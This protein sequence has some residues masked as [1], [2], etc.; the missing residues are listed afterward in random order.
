M[1]GKL[2]SKS[3]G[4]FDDASNA[5]II[6]E[7]GTQHKLFDGTSVSGRSATFTIRPGTVAL[8]TALNMGC[9]DEFMFERV[10]LEGGG[11]PDGILCETDGTEFCGKV[12]EIGSQLLGCGGYKIGAC[13]NV[14][15]LTVPGNYRVVMN[16][17][18][19][20]LGKASL[21]FTLLDA[22]IMSYQPSDMLLKA[23]KQSSCGE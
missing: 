17:K 3:C 13:D 1:A 12:T 7:V 5:V 21:H 11:T 18:D 22:E 14:K 9:G 10:I 19:E 16:C 23:N 2:V 15:Y 8:F 6:S 4:S 20:M